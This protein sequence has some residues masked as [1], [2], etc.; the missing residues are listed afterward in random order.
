M[1][2][3][4]HVGQHSAC[5]FTWYRQHTRPATPD[6]Y[7]DLYRELQSIYEVDDGLTEAVRLDVRK[8][9]EPWMHMERMNAARHPVRTLRQSGPSQANHRSPFGPGMAP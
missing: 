9:I 5:S 6:E 2:C 8:R 7:R 3:Y 4:V 1:S